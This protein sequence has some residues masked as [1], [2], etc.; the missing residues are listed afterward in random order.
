MAQ[1]NSAGKREP[2]SFQTKDVRSSISICMTEYTPDASWR[3]RIEVE[4][5][6]GGRFVL[7]AV[8]TIQPRFRLIRNPNQIVAVC[9]VPNARNWYVYHELLT[10]TPQP[11]HSQVFAEMKM[12]VAPEYAAGCCPL[13]AIPGH[14]IDIEEIDSQS[15]VGGPPIGPRLTLHTGPGWALWADVAYLGGPVEMEVPSFVQ[16]HDA[17]VSDA[18][19]TATM[20]G[21][22][23]PFM[24][25]PIN[26]QTQRLP[27]K[28]GRRFRKGF[29]LALSSTQNTFTA[30]A[31]DISAFGHWA[32]DHD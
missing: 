14:S 21:I 17:G 20:D 26:F 8:D 5:E 2:V 15:P 9:S 23:Y 22:G 1:I 4:V 32:I 25:T 11:G 31:A 29:T 19:S 27:W 16:L 24:S 30:K 12:S 3:L 28:P 6:D 13:V 18:V 7:G 10:G